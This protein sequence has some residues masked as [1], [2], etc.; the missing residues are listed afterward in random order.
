MPKFGFKHS[1]ASKQMMSRSKAAL[2]PAEQR[3]WERVVRGPKG[4]C[5]NW[6]GNKDQDGY[7]RLWTGK[8]TTPAHRFSWQIRYG[9]IPN[10]FQVLHKCDNPSC[11]NPHHL[12][13][14]TPRENIDDM[15]A[16]GRSL[17]GE[18]HSLAKLTESQAI[19]VLRWRPGCGEKLKDVAKRLRVSLSAIELI[20]SGRNWSHLYH[21]H[22]RFS[23]DSIPKSR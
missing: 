16:K 18:K 7:G 5:W 13:L 15:L 3:F 11:V 12:F 2:R 4:V 6:L 19:E 10:G 17:K 22:S 9:S 20:R 8:R 14:G 21:L 1:E 23:N